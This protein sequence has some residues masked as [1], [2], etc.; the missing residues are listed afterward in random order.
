MKLLVHDGLGVWCA[1]RRLN[2]GRFACRAR[3]TRPCL[4]SRG[5][6]SMPWCRGCRGSGS[7]RWTKTR[8]A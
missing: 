3:A 4:R 5:H 8:R 1:T 2:Q 7:S 6:S